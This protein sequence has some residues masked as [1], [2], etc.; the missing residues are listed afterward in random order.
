MKTKLILG[1][2]GFLFTSF[3]SKTT[4]AQNGTVEEVIIKK[5]DTTPNSNRETQEIII[6]KKGNKDTKVTLEITDGKVLI[7]GKP[8][9]EF[10]EDGITINNRK[11]IIREGNKITMNFDDDITL[12][13]DN[14]TRMNDD[15]TS[16]LDKLEGLDKLD[17]MDFSGF[18]ST[19]KT[20]LGVVS[21]KSE[22]GAKIIS[23]EKASPAEKAGLKIDDIIYKVNDTKIDGMQQLSEVITEMKVGEKASVY[24]LRDGKKESVIAILGEKK[25][26]FTIN[27]DYSMMYK[28]P[29]GKVRSLKMPKIQKFK[30]LQEFNNN[31]D[32]NFDNQSIFLNI[33]KPKLGIKIQDT[34]EGNGVKI[35]DVE[36]ESTSAKAGLLKDDIVTE[37]GGVKV[38]NTDEAREQLKVNKEK[39]T[40]TIKA[41]RE[42]KEMEF[43]IKIPKKLKTAEL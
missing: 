42:G 23:V 39:T 38:N 29:N 43:T 32:Y 11:V 12:M 15:Y 5:V 18:G 26:N 1:V 27:Q 36:T 8:M 19:S 22:K 20:F 17:G 40:Y 16:M 2:L 30:Q 28:M 25:N 13:N 33:R 35:L 34:E 4:I 31:G 6:R 14:Y 3:L 7:N 21:E 37:I 41:K 9:V 10:K 24:F